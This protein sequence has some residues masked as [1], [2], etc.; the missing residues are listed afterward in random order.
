MNHVNLD[1]LHQRVQAAMEQVEL[2]VLAIVYEKLATARREASEAAAKPQGEGW[3]QDRTG[4]PR[5]GA[6]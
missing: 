5:G 3:Q 1:D 6:A 4:A 2:E